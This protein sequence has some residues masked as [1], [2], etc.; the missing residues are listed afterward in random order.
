MTDIAIISEEN[1]SQC[2]IAASHQVKFNQSDY[3]AFQVTGF[4]TK[5]W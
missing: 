3:V 4:N 5:Y 2:V 1:Y